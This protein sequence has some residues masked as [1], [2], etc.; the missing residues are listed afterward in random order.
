MESK[1]ER[2]QLV[3][4]AGEHA[5]IFKVTHFL[6]S[7]TSDGAEHWNQQAPYYAGA[8]GKLWTQRW[9]GTLEDVN[10][11]IWRAQ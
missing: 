3:N 7:K 9:D 1:V 11:G 2:V 10:G 4:E 8:D 6:L 5:E